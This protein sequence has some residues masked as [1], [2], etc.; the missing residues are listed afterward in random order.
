MHYALL[1]FLVKVVGN[2]KDIFNNQ[3]GERFAEIKNQDAF[4]Y[5]M[6]MIV[7]R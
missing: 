2:G 1:H 5:Q 6:I 3:I 4:I 7:R